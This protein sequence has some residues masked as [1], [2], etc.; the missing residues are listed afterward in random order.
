MAM[1][2]AL[3]V[4][5]PEKAIP[6]LPA[7]APPALIM[8]PLW[9]IAPPEPAAEPPV[10]GVNPSQEKTI[11]SVPRVGEIVASPLASTFTAFASLDMPASMNGLAGFPPIPMDPPH[12]AEAPPIDKLPS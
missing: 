6:P 5:P 9:A 2:P 4:A 11:A 8:P 7:V 12:P 10:L 1:D 3:V